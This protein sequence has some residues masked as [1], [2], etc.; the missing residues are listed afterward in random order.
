MSLKKELL[1]HVTDLAEQDLITKDELIEAYNKGKKNSPD[2]DSV[3]T[4]KLDIAEIL[5]YLGGAIIF[6]GITILIGQNWSTLGIITKILATLGTSAAAY[7]VGTILI[8]EPKTERVSS[9]FYLI[10]ALTMPIGMWIVMNNAGINASSRGSL[11]IISGLVFATY[12]I[13]YTVF[14]KNIFT[15]FSILFGTWFYYTLTNFMVGDSVYFNT[16]KFHEYRTLLAS[17]TYVLLGYSFTDTVRAPLKGFL[18][19]FGSLGLLATTFMLGGWSP[20]QS[21]F[22]ELMYPFIVF[23]S[24]FVSVYI[25]SKAFL[26]WGT[27][28][29]MLFIF[30]LTAEY[31]SDGLGWP[32]AL[33]IAGLLMIGVGYQSLRI[34]NKYQL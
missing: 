24:L 32:L 19:G 3:F 30:K 20:N 17:L 2:Q 31:F 12:F 29:L 26:T 8:R 1:T 18:Y 14:R 22:W 10:S 13:S 25:K 5:Y 9:A 21:I 4:K 33:V 6:I 23:G 27:I 16:N 15:L 34:K 11:A 28:F 7:L